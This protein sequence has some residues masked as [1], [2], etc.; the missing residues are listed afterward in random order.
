MGEI[1]FVSWWW[2]RKAT[3]CSLSYRAVTIH[4]TENRKSCLSVCKDV[5]WEE[6][7]QSFEKER[8]PG[9]IRRYLGSFK[10]FFT[11]LINE[12]REIQGV[13]ANRILSMK[14]R[15]KD[16][17]LPYSLKSLGHQSIVC[18]NTEIMH[19]LQLKEQ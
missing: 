11:F 9:K 10:L 3:G 19:S 12:Q 18:Q 4:P 5:L 13:N 15:V 6:W 14:G 17:I 8:Q 7:I 2:I 16:L 1:S